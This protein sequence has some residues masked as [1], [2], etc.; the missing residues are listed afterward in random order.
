MI[1]LFNYSEE[2]WREYVFDDSVENTTNYRLE[3][4][5]LGRIK[6]F[7]KFHP[8]GK[9]IK[10]STVEGYP[11]VRVT[12][13]RSMLPKYRESLEPLY[14]EIEDLNAEI[15]VLRK[16][17]VQTKQ[18]RGY[19]QSLNTLVIKRDK[20]VQK[21]KK[22]TDKLTRK[23]YTQV[24]VLIHKA[25]AKLFLPQPQENEKFVIHKDWDKTNNLPENLKWATQEEVSKH[26]FSNPKIEL[27]KFKDQLQGIKKK[28]NTKMGKLTENEVLLI[29]RKIKK[30]DTLKTIA[31]RFGVS[32]MQIYR[33][34]TGENWGHLKEVSELKE[35]LSGQ[36]S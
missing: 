34:K 27:K 19:E 10:G 2:V 4:S 16:A 1:N 22:Q 25:V 9:I 14:K 6:S 23:S 5:N 3:I 21:R 36:P 15:K 35:E 12:F 29:K 28:P 18:K 17:D 31:K 33:I 26:Q 24:V 32:D 30:G 13:Y 8:E 11:C 20:L 7:T